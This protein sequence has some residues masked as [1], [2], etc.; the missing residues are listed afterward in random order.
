MTK[1]YIIVDE[2]EKLKGFT[3]DNITM[4][5][6]EC[7]D[8]YYMYRDHSRS[9]TYLFKSKHITYDESPNLISIPDELLIRIRDYNLE[10][11][12]Q[13][14]LEQTKELKK[15][16]ESLK[17]QVYGWELRR[18]L[19]EEEWNRYNK[20]IDKAIDEHPEVAAEIALQDGNLEAACYF[21]AKANEE[22]N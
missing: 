10:V 18:S 20:L 14:T 22:E 6:L 8:D 15:Q 3:C 1:V 12:H 16:V 2:A 5:R 9:D 21:A 19:V 13:R 17:E 4:Q 11:D 7:G